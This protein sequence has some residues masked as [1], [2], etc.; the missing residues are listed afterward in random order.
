M[1][2]KCYWMIRE[3]NE[4]YI[5]NKLVEIYSFLWEMNIHINWVLK[6]SAV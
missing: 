5:F 4:L 2:Q 3:T 6:I 1:H